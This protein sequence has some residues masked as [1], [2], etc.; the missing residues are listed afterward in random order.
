MNIRSM[1]PGDWQHVAEIYR[2]GIATGVAT[3]ET[4]VP[5]YDDWDSKHLTECRVVA[6]DQGKIMG[7]AALSPVSS[8]CV[9]EGVAE[10][11]V[12][13]GEAARGK[14]IGRLLLALLIRESE[15]CGLWT[16]QSGI[17]PQ[18]TASIRVHEALGFRLIGKRERVAKLNGNWFDNLL[19]EKRSQ[20]VG[21]E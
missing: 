20:T 18:N 8:R 5:E 14:G 10:V 12:Y 9:Y 2:Q 1:T 3:F 11:S 4:V 17:F 13:V 21:I 15:S 7:W 16:L 6:E 19:F